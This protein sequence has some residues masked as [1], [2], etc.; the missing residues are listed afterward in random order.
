MKKTIAILA[1]AAVAITTV[2]AGV[3]FG[4]NLGIPL[5][6]PTVA[7]PAPVFVAPPPVC[8]PSPMP[9]TIVEAVPACP[10]PGYVWVG[11]GWGWHENRWAWT[12]GHWNPPARWEHVGNWDHGYRGYR[13]EHRD[14]FHGGYHRDGRR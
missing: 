2:N 4:I 6:V 9:A 1:L 5:P 8:E 13:V 11:G 14:G 12:R 7:V 3:H 10:T